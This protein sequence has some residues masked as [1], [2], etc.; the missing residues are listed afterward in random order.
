MTEQTYAR[1]IVPPTYAHQTTYIVQPPL[2]PPT[3]EYTP[4]SQSVPG[5]PSVLHA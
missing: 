4:V 3:Y 1:P 5:V 2:P